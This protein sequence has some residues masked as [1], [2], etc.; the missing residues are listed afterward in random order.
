[1]SNDAYRKQRSYTIPKSHRKMR[2]GRPYISGVFDCMWC[3]SL[4]EAPAVKRSSRNGKSWKRMSSKIERTHNKWDLR[5][6]IQG[7][8][9][10][11]D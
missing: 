5:K 1:M 11:Q 7:M 4:G 10:D 8:Y 6:E 3:Y 2:R 9:L